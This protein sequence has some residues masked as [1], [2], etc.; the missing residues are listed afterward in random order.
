MKHVV[1]AVVLAALAAAVQAETYRCTVGAKTLL[2][3]RPCDSDVPRQGA[4]AAAPASVAQ[5]VAN[6]IDANYASPYGEWRGQAQF[7]ATV[8]GAIAQ[9]AHAVVPLTIV[10]NPQGKVIGSAPEVG[11]KIKGIAAPGV[12]ATMLNLDLTL[13]ECRYDGYNRRMS[14]YLSLYQAQKHA[15]LSLNGFV[16]S[17]LPKHKPVAYDIRSTMR[18]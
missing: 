12:A 1:V 13:S 10:V 16:V 11:C 2:T 3:D 8:A 7:Q 14:G 15:Q 17:A 4:Q 6:R 18:R 9:E 5:P